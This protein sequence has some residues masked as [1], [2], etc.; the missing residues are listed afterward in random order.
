MDRRSG[1]TPRG[2][3]D[4]DCI[5]TEDSPVLSFLTSL[6]GIYCLECSL[7]NVSDPVLVDLL[8]RVG[9]NAEF[10]YEKSGYK[11]TTTKF[12]LHF[13]LQSQ[14]SLNQH[15]GSLPQ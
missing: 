15:V 1:R 2:D 9:G 5:E 11:K 4:E 12:Q 13:F 10:L 8:H 14:P 7:H 3:R 6:P